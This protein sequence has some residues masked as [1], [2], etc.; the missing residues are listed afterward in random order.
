MII[1]RAQT[2]HLEAINSIIG[3][4]GLFTVNDGHL[5]TKDI[6]LVAIEDDQVVGFMWCGIMANGQK[7]LIDYFAIAPEYTTKGVGNKLATKLQQVL[8]KKYK[9]AVV[10]GFIRQD[11]YHDASAVNCLKLGCA[12]DAYPYTHI[13]TSVQHSVKESVNGR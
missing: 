13:Y 8:S 6:A 10:S 11:K 12:A 5:N 9:D 3:G 1:R 2:R 4:Y 7:A